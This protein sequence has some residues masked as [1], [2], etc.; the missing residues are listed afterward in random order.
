MRTTFTL[1][2]DAA[3]LAQN[4]AKARSLRLCSGG[5]VGHRQV[6]DAWLLSAAMRANMK[7]LTFD[8]GIGQLLAS[9]AERRAYVLT[10]A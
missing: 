6:S 7:L 3:A 1:D 2:D 10:L 4:Y 5:I 8:H 9:D